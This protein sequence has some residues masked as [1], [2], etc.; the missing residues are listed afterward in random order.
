MIIPNRFI[1]A[2][3]L[4]Y[5]R[6]MA[7]R[8]SYRRGWGQFRYLW[9]MQRVRLEPLSPE[10]APLVLRY[11]LAN[12][13]VFVLVALILNLIGHSAFWSYRNYTAVSLAF[14]L[15]SA[16]ALFVIALYS[17][18]IFSM[19]V[20]YW[21]N[22]VDVTYLGGRYMQRFIIN[23]HLYITIRFVKNSR[24]GDSEE[25]VLKQ[26]RM[27]F[28]ISSFMKNYEEFCTHLREIL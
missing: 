28:R 13:V 26:G 25:V 19:Q 8:A 15:T 24:Y 1:A 17:V 21:A 7:R 12:K 16:L 6:R 11:P 9:T 4:N 14:I 27:S 10:Y 23:D 18:F 20:N 2:P 22:K 3:L 5:R